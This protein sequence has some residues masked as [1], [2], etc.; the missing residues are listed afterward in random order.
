MAWAVEHD[1]DSDIQQLCRSNPTIDFLSKGTILNHAPRIR[2]FLNAIPKDDSVTASEEGLQL[3][4]QVLAFLTAT[5]KPSIFHGVLSSDRRVKLRQNVSSHYGR[6]LSFMV[7]P[8]MAGDMKKRIREETKKVRKDLKAT[9]GGHKTAQTVVPKRLEAITS[10]PPGFLD[11]CAAQE[12]SMYLE[13]SAFQNHNAVFEQLLG[14]QRN[15]TE[16]AQQSRNA[17]LAT[18]YTETDF[19]SLT[20]FS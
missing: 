7:P 5:L 15:D 11:M 6:A 2:Q 17:L 14:Q 16:H 3:A 12:G 1:L 19:I 4:V 18:A 9:K 13:P 20:T 8:K 10:S